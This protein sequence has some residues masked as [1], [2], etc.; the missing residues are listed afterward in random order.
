MKKNI[1]KNLTIKIISAAIAL[2]ISTSANSA[3]VS[4]LG[5]LAYYDDVADLTWLA[6]AN[7]AQTS[8]YDTNG[9]MTWDQANAWAAG[10]DIDGVAGADGWRLPDT[11]DV[12]NDGYTYTN[13]YQGVDY[14]FNITTHSEMSNMFYNVL[15]NTAWYD[16]SGVATGCTVP[17]Y[18][19]TNTGSFSN[20]QSMDY[21][22]ATEYA[23]SA[24][25]GWLFG[26]IDGFQSTA[27]KGYGG[28]A[29]LVQS[30]DVSAVPVPAAV[31]LFGSGL[32][33]LLGVARCKKKA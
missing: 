22:S 31:W 12:G 15:G 32:I 23:L 4:R 11:I 1:H 19:L 24:G 9:R 13:I 14:G 5:G 30:G 6:D 20:L 21:W 25:R 29:W 8:G 7:Y 33:G 28:Y 17:D 2:G 18:C 10:L 16:T 27:D 3:L 26:M